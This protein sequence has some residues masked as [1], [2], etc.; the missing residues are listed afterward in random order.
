[1]RRR[2]HVTG[3]SILGN[4]IV[5]HDERHCDPSGC[6]S[7]VDHC[8]DLPAVNLNAIEIG[9]VYEFDVISYYDIKIKGS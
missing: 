9:Q 7:K 5:G 4:G 2:F 6:A 8:I 1:M 3:R